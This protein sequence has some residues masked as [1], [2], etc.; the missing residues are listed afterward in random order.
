MARMNPELEATLEALRREPSAGFEFREG[1]YPEA[2]APPAREE[3]ARA[4]QTKGARKPP[5]AGK[6]QLD[7]R[8]PQR[9][10]AG[11]GMEGA[12][13]PSKTRVAPP[14][15]RRGG[16]RNEV[17]TNDEENIS[18]LISKSRQVCFL[19]HIKHVSKYMNSTVLKT[20]T[21]IL[22]CK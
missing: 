12:K 8:L 18:A 22:H 5:P 15:D 7:A 10:D 17:R 21:S 11:A 6:R 2:E 16:R 9:F 4:K 1:N 20:S 13:Q 3:A 14:G 19:L